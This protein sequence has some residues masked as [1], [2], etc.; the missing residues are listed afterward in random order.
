MQGSFF[1]STF[2]LKKDMS[3]EIACERCRIG[4][5]FSLQDVVLECCKI[6]YYN[7]FPIY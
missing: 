4:T 6:L 2:E 7:A 5:N 1:L 3:H